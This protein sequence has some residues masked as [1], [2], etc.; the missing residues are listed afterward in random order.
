[1]KTRIFDLALLM[2]VLTATTALFSCGGADMD[3][4]PTFR[5]MLK[6]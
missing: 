2:F 1:M 5:Q 6:M 3:D 4:N